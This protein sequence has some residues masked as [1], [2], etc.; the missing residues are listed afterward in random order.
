MISPF[1]KKYRIYVIIGLITFF[2]AFALW[3]RLI[4][5]FNLGNLDIL[6]VVGSDDPLYNLRQVEQMLHNFPQY[7]WF[8]AMTHFPKGD[9]IYWGPLFTYILTFMSMITGAATRPDII[10]ASL[11][12]PPLMATVLVP[13]MY[14]VGKS[15]GD[16]KTGL[17]ASGFIAVVSGQYYYRSFFG[18]LDH[19]IAEVFFSTLFCLA[20]IWA[21]QVAKETHLDFKKSET[22]KKPV[23]LALLGGIAYL[24]GLFTMPTIV[25]FAM[26][27]AIFTLV[28]FV[29]DFYRGQNGCYLLL[30]NG[31]IFS[32]AILGLLLFG[33]KSPEQIS[34]AVYS[35]GHVYAYLGLIGG[36][37]ALYLLAR[38]TPPAK[39]YLY[40]LAII[41]IGLL[42]SLVLYVISPAI[43]DLLISSF[44]SFFGQAAEVLT[45]QEARGWDPDLAWATFNYGLVLMAGGLA[46]LAYKNIREEHPHQVFTLIWSLIIL[47]STWQHIRYEYY[48]AVNVAL[49]S[50][51]V[52]SFVVDISW[53]P[54]LKYLKGFLTPSPD[55]HKEQAPVPDT[56]RERKRK[57]GGNKPEQQKSYKDA[58]FLLLLIG[59]TI[60]ALMF[61]YTS[62][63]YSYT[64]AAL[65][66]IRMNQD[67]RESLEWLGNNTP[68]TGVD[69]FAVYDQKT[70]R[71]PDQAYGIMSWWDYGHMIT[72]I[73]KRIPNANPFQRGVAG[74][75]G[76]AAFF[77]TTSE[78][79]ADSMADQLGT[80]YVITDIEMDSGKFWAMATWF[81][82]SA[83][84]QPYQTR[85]AAQDPDQPD[86]YQEVM[87][88]TQSYYLTM[89][90]RLH[91]FDGSMTG[92]EKAYYVE[93]AD[94][95]VTHISVPV[96]TNA[97]VINAS[98]SLDR[99]AQYNL[100]APAGY[101]A[102]TYSPAIYL[103]V[104]PVPALRHYRLV[105]ESPTNVFAASTPDIKYVKI[106]EYVKGAHIRGEG[107]IEVPVISDTGRQFTYRQQST[108][109]E[110]IVPYSTSGNP[111]GVKVVGK[112]R[113][114]D[115][116]QVFDVPESAVLQGLTIN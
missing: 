33:I 90:S 72:F 89:I 94:P 61:V 69:Y 96:I 79:A 43:F 8:D 3:L 115:T 91:N 116:N 60:L 30:V 46:V 105:H 70:Y 100:K 10:F 88:N 80:R 114:A 75:V 20:Y 103:P 29:I 51:V 6:N 81:N 12:V 74:D 49:L 4:P 36:T 83:G 98:E 16:W 97:L 5:L 92:T 7:A 35:F 71:Y 19:H 62:V 112:Y 86:R 21:I 56:K 40:P 101:R 22:I 17:F 64:N 32:L 109:G 55:Q 52:L 54:S 106:F 23:F 1:Q 113:I 41:G 68:D 63:N 42:F 104:E 84:V 93:Y 31:I 24:L 53:S 65:N 108:N 47:I 66:P 45:V 73:A 85:F 9:F 59:T 15:C 34:L 26:I 25:L 102:A 95:G 11:L 39:R 107:I 38:L 99:A 87:L 13:V 37:A 14:F 111:Y 28:Q 58:T 67:W 48:L 77:M 27:V 44:F 76:A 50:G 110:F 78:A 57:K 2:S 18:Y 82:T